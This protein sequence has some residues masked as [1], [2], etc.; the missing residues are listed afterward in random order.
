M[1]TGAPDPEPQP[2]GIEA[3]LNT[4]QRTLA[5]LPGKMSA[6]ISE[7]QETRIAERVYNLFEQ[8]GAFRQEEAKEDE[9]PPADGEGATGEPEPEKRG[10]FSGF[11]RRFA[12]E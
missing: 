9:E 6:S 4:L 2:T 8:G 1:S 5:E 7:E 11:A 3:M 10:G 12:G